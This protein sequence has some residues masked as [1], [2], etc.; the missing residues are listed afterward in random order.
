[1]PVAQAVVCLTRVVVEGDEQMKVLTGICLLL[2]VCLGSPAHADSASKQMKVKELLVLMHLEEDSNRMLKAQEASIQTMSEQQLAG[3][4][5]DPEQK[6]HYE[7]F[8][9]Q[10]L[11]LL[12][13]ALRWDAMEGDYVK[14]YVETYSESEVDGMLAFYRS[15]VGRAVV[16][17]TPD[18]T[19]RSMFIAQTRIDAVKPKIQGLLDRLMLEMQ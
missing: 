6:K 3:A 10:V 13:D 18:L 19:Q 16:A 8:R 12:R 15:P 17:K 4:N 9:A 14:L 11:K 2:A 5:P 1:V 7:V